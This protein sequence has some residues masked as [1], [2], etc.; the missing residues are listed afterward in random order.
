MEAVKIETPY[1]H[2]AYL[3]SPLLPWS[4]TFPVKK[5]GAMEQTNISQD[6]S[7]R[8]IIIPHSTV[9]T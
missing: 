7:T 1:G 8:S 9:T 5:G 3:E 4:R 2:M 6:N